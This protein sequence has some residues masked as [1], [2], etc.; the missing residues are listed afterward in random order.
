MMDF[1]LWSVFEMLVALA[2]GVV[3]VMGLTQARTIWRVRNG[4]YI[5]RWVV[6]ILCLLGGGLCLFSVAMMYRWHHDLA[7][8]TSIRMLMWA[9]NVMSLVGVLS[10]MFK[11][12]P[13]L[14]AG[15]SGMTTKVYAMNP[16][17][18]DGSK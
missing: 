18:D 17:G 1:H 6:L 15:H 10:F 8:M 3:G 9:Q 5:T 12:V 16:G 13:H 11:L 7:V 4:G 2:F 14:E